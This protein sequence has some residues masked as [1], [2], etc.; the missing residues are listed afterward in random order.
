[1]LML[2]ITVQV[3]VLLTLQY[4]INT[5][6][7][8]SLYMWVCVWSQRWGDSPVFECPRHFNCYFSLNQER[9]ILN[10]T[11][12]VLNASSTIFYCAKKLNKMDLYVLLVFFHESCSHQLEPPV[13]FFCWRFPLLQIDRCKMSTSK[14]KPTL[15]QQEDLKKI[16]LFVK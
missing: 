6:R 10:Q 15:K 1:M 4:S 12:L 16:K 3:F 11:I 5:Y 13:S 8:L 2:T 9:N 7:I 14:W